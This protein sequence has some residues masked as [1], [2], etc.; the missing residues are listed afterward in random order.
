M[1]KS[2]KPSCQILVPNCIQNVKHELK[3]NAKRTHQQIPEPPLQQKRKHLFAI[4]RNCWLPSSSSLQ[5]QQKNKSNSKSFQPQI[6]KP[7]IN[8]YALFFLFC[9]CL[10]R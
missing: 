1:E 5:I 9:F 4:D 3:R 6:E 10:D 8:K 7:E 2:N